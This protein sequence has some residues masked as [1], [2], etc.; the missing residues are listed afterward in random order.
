MTFSTYSVRVALVA[1][2]FASGSTANVV[3]FT[4]GMF[5]QNDYGTADAPNAAAATAPLWNLTWTDWFLHGKCRDNPPPDNEFLNVPANGAFT[6]EIA[7]NRAWTTLSYNGGK[8]SDWPD[9]K[10]HPDNW[11]TSIVDSNYPPSTSGC[12]GSPNIHAHSESDAAGTAFAISYNN[13]INTV[14]VS[15]FTVFSVLPNTPYKRIATY[16]VPNLP[17]CP[18]G[19]C[20]CAWA[21]IPNHCGQDSIYMNAYRCQVTGA[22][23]SAKSLA[24]PVPAQWCESDPSKCID[25]PKQ[26]TVQYQAQGNNV[27]LPSGNQKDGSKPSPGYN[28]KMGFK[29]GAQTD[30]F[31]NETAPVTPN[32]CADPPTVIVMETVTVTL[33]LPSE[34]SPASRRS[35]FGK[36]NL[37]FAAQK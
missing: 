33:D 6:V 26:M 20:L 35:L 32:T 5:C 15:D 16:Q 13:D 30:I 37:S 1:A 12:I 7:S 11:S 24:S 29:S 36:R 27:K 18:S 23:A 8:A 3:A 9:G 22:T 25:G 34:T 17:A 21:W 10:V 31:S 28:L 19:G 14:N 4:K 2:V